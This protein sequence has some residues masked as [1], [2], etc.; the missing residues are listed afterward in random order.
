MLHLGRLP[1]AAFLR[2]L[3]SLGSQTFDLVRRPEVSIPESWRR[4]SRSLRKLSNVPSRVVCFCSTSAKPALCICLVAA[5]KRL[6]LTA[7]M[8]R[9]RNACPSGTPSA[10]V[11]RNSMC[12]ESACLAV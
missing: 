4:L 1:T 7:P 11:C 6:V 10:P 2:W 3:L 8:A 12:L 5:L 9:K